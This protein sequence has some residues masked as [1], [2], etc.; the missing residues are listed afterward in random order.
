[1][2][3]FNGLFL[4]NLSA[5]NDITKDLVQGAIQLEGRRRKRRQ[6]TETSTITVDEPISYNPD[7]DPPLVWN[8]QIFQS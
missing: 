5:G 4:C 3:Y 6:A 2:C 1:M 7:A 8:M